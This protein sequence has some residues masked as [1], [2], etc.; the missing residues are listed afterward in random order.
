[1]KRKACRRNRRALLPDKPRSQLNGPRII[2]LTLYQTEGG[3]RR[4]AHVGRGEYRVIHHIKYL[5]AELE[6]ISLGGV[7]IIQKRSIQLIQIL[8]PDVPEGSWKAA[9]VIRGLIRRFQVKCR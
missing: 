3:A 1:M 5:K 7:G 6:V 4:A 2:R 9:D 8:L